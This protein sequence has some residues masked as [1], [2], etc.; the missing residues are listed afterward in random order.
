[1]NSAN[2][3]EE[4]V[5]TIGLIKPINLIDKIERNIIRN[6]KS[7]EAKSIQSG[8]TN[9]RSVQSVKME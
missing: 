2:D 1:M 5:V 7:L 9:Q 3:G 4:V 6:V 8:T